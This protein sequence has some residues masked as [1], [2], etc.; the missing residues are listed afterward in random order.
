VYILVAKR[1]HIRLS[2]SYLNALFYFTGEGWTVRDL[3][4]GEDAIE[5]AFF[6]C[7]RLTGDYFRIA[8]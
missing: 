7:L 6:C 4:D 5:V 8:T 3:D 2:S 1:T